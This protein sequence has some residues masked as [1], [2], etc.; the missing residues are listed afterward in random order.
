MY[1]L[2]YTLYILATIFILGCSIDAKLLE[3]EIILEIFADVSPQFFEERNKYLQNFKDLSKG[4]ITAQFPN[5][6]YI[7]NYVA[8]KKILA[9]VKSDVLNR[10]LLY[11]GEKTTSI[12]MELH[13]MLLDHQIN[14]AAVD[15]ASKNAEIRNKNERIQRRQQLEGRVQTIIMETII[16]YI[17]NMM[18]L[19]GSAKFAMKKIK[20]NNKPKFFNHKLEMQLGII[21]DTAVENY[22]KQN[23]PEKMNSL[24]NIL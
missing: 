21:Q 15:I 7:P 5:V 23:K 14:M 20:F 1:P 13:H 4:N 16:G 24:I 19:K 17:E 22:H 3:S 18:H 12:T 10:F 8:L 9:K 11:L 6:A 2:K